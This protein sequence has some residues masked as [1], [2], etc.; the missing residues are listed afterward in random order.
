MTA[1]LYFSPSVGLNALCM[2]CFHIVA[3]LGDQSLSFCGAVEFVSSLGGGLRWFC[4][5]LLCGC[6]LRWIDTNTPRM[7]VVMVVIFWLNFDLRSLETFFLSLCLFSVVN[8]ELGG[9][10]RQV[11]LSKTAAGE[12]L[13]RAYRVHGTLLYHMISLYEYPFVV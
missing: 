12:C 13:S 11:F 1:M 7:H 4:F 6:C 10:C 3:V 5:L 8:L 2:F 9:L